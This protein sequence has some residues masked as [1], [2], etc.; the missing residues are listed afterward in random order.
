MSTNI[1]LSLRAPARTL[2]DLKNPTFGSFL[3]LSRWI[4]CWIVFLG[5]L[6]NPLFLG[7][8][9]VASEDRNLLVA[10][11]Y[12]VTGWFGE[13]VIV[14]F[15]LS[16]YLVGAV[17]LAKASVGRFN[18]SDYAIDRFSRVFLPFAPAL[19]LTA[20]CDSA[21]MHLFGGLGFYDNS[22]PM[23][24]AKI[25]GAYFE[26]FLTLKNF[27]ANLLMAQTIVTPPFGSN[28]PLWTIS[29][30][31]W[32]YVLGGLVAAS[33]TFDDRGRRLAALALTA[34]LATAL[35]PGF[36]LNYMGLWLIG[37]AVGFISAPALERP[38]LSIVSL[39]AGLVAMRFAKGLFEHTGALGLRN[40]VIA[41]LFAW[42][43]LSLRSCSLGMLQSARAFNAFAASFS[44][45]LYLIHF[46]LML[47]LLGAL[48]ATGMFDKIAE[49]YPPTDSRGLLAYAIVAL[50]VGVCAFLFSACTER[51]TLRM[52]QILKI[53]LVRALSLSS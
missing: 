48:A 46:P 47:F 35:G 17:S 1:E 44:Y 15:V 52:R 36:F 26:N 45:S 24:H 16:G 42:V 38:I 23:L 3:D 50:L 33:I 6:R 49:G 12:F 2:D 11:W 8:E 4:C 40:Y 5:H 13:A 51:Q 18:V 32:F 25:A 20:L 28:G 43:L 29:L 34:V 31:F 39:L 53:K 41:I 19:L 7:Y 10:I 9:A 27:L 14:F 21:G 30:E 22:H 37:A